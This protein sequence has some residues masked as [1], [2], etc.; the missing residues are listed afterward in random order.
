M[1][2][3]MFNK[4][5]NTYMNGGI[6]QG[7]MLDVS[8]FPVMIKNLKTRNPTSKFM[9]DTT[10]HETTPIFGTDL[11]QKYLN[12]VTEWA[13]DNDM[14]LNATNIKQ[15]PLNVNTNIKTSHDLVV[16]LIIRK[17]SNY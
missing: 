8:L 3:I 4:I 11:L 17:L 6:P 9:D 10:L 2:N 7:T 5:I 12:I 13:S 14:S 1:F 15:L 16:I